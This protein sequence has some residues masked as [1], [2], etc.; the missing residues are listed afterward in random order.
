MSDLHR[1]EVAGVEVVREA[2]DGIARARV[3]H[4]GI[5]HIAIQVTVIVLRQ[6]G[7]RH[8]IGA[9]QLEE[10]GH[11]RRLRNT[12]RFFEGVVGEFSKL[13]ATVYIQEKIEK[14]LREFALA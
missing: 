5:Q 9:R 4:T 10:G 7:E 8:N 6:G 14:V 2:R 12:G 1:L 13:V 11:S 3:R